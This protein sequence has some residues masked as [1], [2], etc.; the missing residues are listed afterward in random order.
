M[1]SIRKRKWFTPTQRK[2]IDPLAKQLAGSNWEKLSRQERGKFL[3]EAAQSLGI[4]PEEGWLVAY[5][6][7]G[8]RRFKAF[9]TKAEA[10][11]WSI[12]AL[13]EVQLGIHT[14]SSTSKTVAE[15][16]GL[17]LDHCEAEGLEEYTIEQRRQHLNL[18]VKPFIGDVKLSDLTTP[19]VYDFDRKLRDAG[20][21]LS[22]RRKVNTNLKTMLTYAQGH[23]PLVA[24]N[25]ARGVKIKKDEREEAS[26]PLRAG[27]DFPSIPELNQ[28]IEGAAGRW[29]P[30][31]VTA[32]F[33][34][35]RASE[36][37]GLPWSNVDLD[38]GLIHVRQRADKGGNIGPPK[39]KKGKRDIPLPPIAVNALRQWKD[40]CP[41]GEL[42][43]VFPNGQGNVESLSNVY[44]RFWQPLQIKLGMATDTGEKDAE[45]NPVMVHRYGFH[46]LRH[47]AA[48][49]FIKY[50]GWKPQRI[51]D[52]MGHSSITITYDL[53]GHLFEDTE[54]D[55]ADMEKIEAAIKVA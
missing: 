23:G 7:K 44:D 47:A 15:A 46:M 50:L 9:G 30:F 39:S 42:E 13:H 14:P 3:D 17:W 20:R 54:A 33:T 25:V 45:G 27:V 28:I 40:E 19:M 8:E 5:E 4:K 38:A 34:G 24:Q 6:D 32:I 1:A 11:D 29:R 16:W 48:S 21:S 35:M 43:L 31:I 36:L 37:R 41:K 26:G 55:R 18:H 51:R 52:V 53:Y 2:S 22:M 12:T 49:L 10:K